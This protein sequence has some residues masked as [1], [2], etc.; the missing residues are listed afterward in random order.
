MNH[1]KLLS[2]GYPPANNTGLVRNELAV[3]FLDTGRVVPLKKNETGYSMPITA[4][5]VSPH[6]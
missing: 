2:Y 6:K 4:V 3:T 1:D 5:R